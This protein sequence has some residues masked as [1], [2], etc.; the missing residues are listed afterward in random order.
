[1]SDEWEGNLR[2]TLAPDLMA[3]ASLSFLELFSRQSFTVSSLQAVSMFKGT[4][5]F[6]GLTCKCFYDTS[7]AC[8]PKIRMIIL[9]LGILPSSASVI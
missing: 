6:V 3:H 7:V 1:M 2:E 8:L 9:Y 4:W 5:I